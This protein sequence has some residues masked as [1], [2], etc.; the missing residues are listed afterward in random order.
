[1]KITNGVPF[2][3]RRAACLCLA[4][5]LVSCASQPPQPAAPPG[6][7]AADVAFETLSRRWFD[8]MLALSPVT[9]TGLG[10][11]RFDDKLDDVGATGRERRLALGRELLNACA[12]ST[13]S[14]FPERTRSM[15]A[16]WRASSSTTSGARRSSQDWRWDPLI[17]T[18]LAGSSVVLLLARDFAPMPDR[19]RNVQARLNELP[20][21]LAQVRESLDHC[22]RSEDS[23]G[24]G[25]Q[26]ERWRGVAHR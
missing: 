8:E 2:Y 26:A 7:S 24:D 5:L 21:L 25:R 23:C 18:N 3:S 12:R 15:H 10:D 19:L 20:R 6:P 22:A 14:S 16:C 13:R 9:A 1:M 17:Y 4:A 11:H